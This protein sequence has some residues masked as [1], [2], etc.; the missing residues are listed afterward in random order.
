M[1]EWSFIPHEAEISVY[2]EIIYGSNIIEILSDS[3]K[4]Y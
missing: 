3:S 2:N 1:I 4:G